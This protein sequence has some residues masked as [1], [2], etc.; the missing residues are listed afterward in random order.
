[1]RDMDG[2]VFRSVGV[3]FASLTWTSPGHLG[4]LLLSIPL[5]RIR[6]FTPELV[7][8]WRGRPSVTRF[9]TD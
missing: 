8:A 7:M 2:P 9:A 6:H 4:A 5:D 1:M 3:T